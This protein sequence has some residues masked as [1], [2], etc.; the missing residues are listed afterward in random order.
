L[1]F[2]RPDCSKLHEG[3]FYDLMFPRPKFRNANYQAP[4][5][6]SSAP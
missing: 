6:P 5:R 2:N 3:L 1:N 4:E